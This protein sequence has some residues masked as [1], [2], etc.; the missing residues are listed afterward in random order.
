MRSYGRA[1][2]R[3][4]ADICIPSVF[5]ATLA[6]EDKHVM[7]MFT[8]WV[9]H[10]WATVPDRSA[11]EAYASR[12]IDRVEALAPGFKSSILH[13]QVIG[14]YEMESEYGLVGGNDFSTES[15]R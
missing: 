11:L 12:V 7:S 8:Q 1:A 4:F 6:P 5:D 2:E 9:P 10:E 13:R 3:P 15:S 14:P